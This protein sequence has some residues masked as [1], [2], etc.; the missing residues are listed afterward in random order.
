MFEE[1]GKHGVRHKSLSSL[2]AVGV[3]QVS[4]DAEVKSVS[5]AFPLLVTMGVQDHNQCWN[6]LV[7]GFLRVLS[8]LLSAVSVNE[9]L[10]VGLLALVTLLALPDLVPLLERVGRCSCR[11]HSAECRQTVF[12]PLNWK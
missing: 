2:F 3:D 9:L 5:E 4:D 7:E 8:E 10:H 11:T 6:Q 1:E 12:E